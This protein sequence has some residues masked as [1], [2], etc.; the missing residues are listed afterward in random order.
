MHQHAYG[1]ERRICI[2]CSKNIQIFKLGRIARHTERRKHLGFSQVLR[3]V[4]SLA[5]FSHIMHYA[6]VFQVRK[7]VDIHMRTV[8]E[9]RQRTE[10]QFI[11]NLLPGHL[12]TV[13]A[14]HCNNSTGC[15]Q[16]HF[17]YNKFTH[18]VFDFALKNFVR[19]F[20]GLAVDSLHRHR[21]A[22]HERA[23]LRN[24]CHVQILDR[25]DAL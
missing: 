7:Q 23:L 18:I 8:L 15:R 1:K 19:E 24:T 22:L 13:F 20:H 14:S 11:R 9:I 16:V 2:A 5:L 25:G 10:R 3:L 4:E 21:R 17:F 6:L 12:A